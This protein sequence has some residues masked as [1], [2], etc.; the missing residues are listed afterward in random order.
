MILL[1]WSLSGV[2]AAFWLGPRATSRMAWAP[3]AALLGPLWA[4]VAV[5]QRSLERVRA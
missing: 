2:I 4:F 1:M 5:E 3:V